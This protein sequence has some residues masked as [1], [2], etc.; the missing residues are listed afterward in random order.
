M[1][2]LND[3]LRKH[4]QRHHNRCHYFEVV[5]VLRLQLATW[6]AEVMVNFVCD[7]EEVVQGKQIFSRNR[8]LS[9]A[10]LSSRLTHLTSLLR[11]TIE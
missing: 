1:R 6:T 3:T 8:R 10:N 5:D 7:I 4:K 9:F 11:L 2:L